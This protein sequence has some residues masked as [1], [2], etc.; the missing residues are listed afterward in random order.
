MRWGQ[1]DWRQGA[2]CSRAN[3]DLFVPEEREHAYV[4]KAREWC[5]TCPVFDYCLAYGLEH[6]EERGIYAGLS[7]RDRRVTR[8]EGF[9]DWR[10]EEPLQRKNSLNALAGRE[11]VALA[12]GVEAVQG[13]TLLWSYDVDEWDEVIRGYRAWAESVGWNMRMVEA[14]ERAIHL[15]N[16]LLQKRQEHEILADFRETVA[17][18]SMYRL[19]VVT[20]SPVEWVEDTV[21]Y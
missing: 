19:D 3:P 7:Q 4:T 9:L 6:S 10:E 5:R 8:T 16:K 17:L 18:R 11:R 20:A 2:S 15:S 1:Q 14:E 13:A 12:K 21:S